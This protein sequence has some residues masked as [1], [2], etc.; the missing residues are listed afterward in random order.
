MWAVI[1]VSL[2]L[3]VLGEREFLREGRHVEWDIGDINHGPYQGQPEQVHLAF[4]GN[5]IVKLYF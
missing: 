5:S 4:D 1:F 2:I 3:N